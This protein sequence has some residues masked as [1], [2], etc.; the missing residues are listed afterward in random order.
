MSI[1]DFSFNSVVKVVDPS[2]YLT[3][4]FLTKM[5]K[6]IVKTSKKKCFAMG[7][8][9]MVFRKVLISFLQFTPISKII[10]AQSDPIFYTEL[11]G[12]PFQNLQKILQR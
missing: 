2:I 3:K 7:M 1:D 9:S 8:A 6:Q 4:T 10:Y 12:D 5:Q 11:Q